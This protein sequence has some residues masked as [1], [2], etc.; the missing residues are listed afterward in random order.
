[1]V[2]NGVNNKMEINNNKKMFCV[3][4]FMRETVKQID[5]LW[6]RKLCLLITQEFSRRG[7]ADLDDKDFKEIFLN[8][9]DISL[10]N[11]SQLCDLME[12]IINILNDKKRGE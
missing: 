1:M 6:L 10:L 11:E 3:D 2:K 12:R 5:D 7:I 9:F 8:Y 4:D